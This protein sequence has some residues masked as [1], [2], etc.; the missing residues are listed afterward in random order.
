[1][2][3]YN[4]PNFFISDILSLTIFILFMKA[5]KWYSTSNASRNCTAISLGFFSSQW[6]C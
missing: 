1:M 4:V 5:D 2:A 3:C 6:N